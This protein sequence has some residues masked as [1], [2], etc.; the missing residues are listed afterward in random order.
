[1]PAAVIYAG[2][3]A[4]DLPTAAINGDSV[5]LAALLAAGAAV[6]AK[7]EGG[8]TALMNA[9]KVGSF[10]CVLALLKAGADVNCT[11]EHGTALLFAARSGKADM[12]AALLRAGADV[13][14]RASN[15][16]TPLAAASGS[17]LTDVVALLLNAGAVTRHAIGAI[18]TAEHSKHAAVREQAAAAEKAAR[19]A[20]WPLPLLTSSTS[21]IGTPVPSAP[22][23]PTNLAPGPA[24][25]DNWTI[26][27][28]DLRLG[29]ELGGGS[30]GRVYKARWRGTEVAVKVFKP[31]G[32]SA[33]ESAAFSAALLPKIRAEAGLLAA[34]RHPHVV[35]FYGVAGGEPGS[36]EPP[37]VVTEFCAR[38]S[39]LD[40]LRGAAGDRSKAAEL[41]WRRRLRLALDAAAGV[42]HLHEQAPP[43]LHRDLKSPNLLVTADWRCKVADLG[44]SKLLDGAAAATT[45]GGA[46]NPRWVA[47]EVMGGEKAAEAAD[48]FS[49]GIVLWE[50]LTWELPW[51][52]LASNPWA[53][54]ALSALFIPSPTA[55]L[56]AFAAQPLSPRARAHDCCLPPSPAQLFKAVMEGQRPAVPDRAALPGP[57]AAAF[58]GLDDYVALMRR[59]WEQAPEKRP[60]F[61][62]VVTALSGM[63]DACA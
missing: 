1:M 22:P 16:M 38:G 35:A 18:P 4:H 46:G 6:D 57:G 29:A 45:A 52:Q 62:E 12:V 56:P 41:T 10:A 43:I 5:R 32:G 42:L 48:V 7:T 34:L 9:A 33:A 20:A 13:N 21:S 44:L 14:A 39:L 27:R 23:A 25:S 58:A 50:L 31:E 11:G 55:V 2:D 36:R 26:R 40:V 61:G 30:F 19:T 53:V 59:C 3:A 63:L 49:F 60:P 28:A 47:P 15:G 37:C 54:R 8:V 51:A 24:L 17:G